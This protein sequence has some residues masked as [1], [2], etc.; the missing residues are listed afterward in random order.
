MIPIHAN[1]HTQ[2]T[3]PFSSI[4][5]F[6]H[7]F[8]LCL[9]FCRLLCL[10]SSLSHFLSSSL[11]LSSSLSHY[12][13]L[14]VMGGWVAGESTLNPHPHPYP[15]VNE[16]TQLRPSGYYIHPWPKSG[17]YSLAVFNGKSLNEPIEFYF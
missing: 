3:R 4:S 16:H 6:I 2:L 7:H 11:P 8:S 12:P 9:T 10:S 15:N 1:E 17:E 14:Y 5:F 13:T